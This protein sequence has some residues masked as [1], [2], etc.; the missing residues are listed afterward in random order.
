[1]SGVV[2]KKLRGSRLGLESLRGLVERLMR[3]FTCLFFLHLVLFLCPPPKKRSPYFLSTP[4][5]IKGP[6]SD[7]C[8]KTDLQKLNRFKKT[9]W[10]EKIRPEV[11]I[12]LQQTHQ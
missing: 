11:K 3:K 12:E 5:K 6:F 2:D 10:F 1:M 4:P 8:L 9:N 7:S